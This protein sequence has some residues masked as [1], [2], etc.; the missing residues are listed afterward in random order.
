MLS[1]PEIYKLVNNY[2]EVHG[3]YLGDFSY[4]TH[5]EFYPYYCDLDIDPN[6]YEGT[7][8]ERFLQILEG[9]DAYTQ[10]IIVKGILA[11]YPITHFNEEVREQKQ[12]LHDEFM[13]IAA[14][15]ER[16]A[17]HGGVVSVI[18][19]IIFAPDGRHPDVVLVD[20]MNNDTRLV[21]DDDCLSYT[22]L[23]PDTGLMWLDLVA[24][25]ANREELASSGRE[26]EE[27]LYRRLYKTLGSPP[28]QLLFDTYFGA[29]HDELGERF[30]AL[31]PQVYLHY[32]PKT[33]RKII[34]RQRM[35]FL[36]LF[37]NHDRIVIE[38][39]GK[40][41]YAEGDVASPKL[42]AQMAKADR[43]LRLAGYEMYRFGGY[44]LYEEKGRQIVRDFFWRLFDKHEIA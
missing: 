10:A 37:S 8:R 17:R 40:Q 18:K 4:R 19:N 35:D 29:F 1:K 34:P 16:E 24:W 6:G 2:I 3:G 23:I 30:P 25:W 27:T 9:S 12:A 20:A 31:I 5:E 36:L 14:R 42:Y 15:L 44:E 43:E 39:D 32:D 38:V 41:H 13:T 21:N 33:G 22:D 11:K 7:T 28:E 26:A